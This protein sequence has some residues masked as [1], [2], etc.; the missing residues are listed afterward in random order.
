MNPKNPFVIS[1]FTNP[2]REIVFRV[3]GW[4]DGQRIRKNFPTRPE[5][6]AERQVLEI[7][8]LQFHRKGS[9]FTCYLDTA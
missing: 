2:S 7:Q 4:L 5:A 3:S 1:Q 6:E 9:C 8:R